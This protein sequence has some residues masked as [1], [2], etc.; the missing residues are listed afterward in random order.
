MDCR[1]DSQDP[2]VLPSA[3]PLLRVLGAFVAGR[4]LRSPRDVMRKQ[5]WRQ[6]VVQGLSGHRAD[7]LYPQLNWTWHQRKNACRLQS[8]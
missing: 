2:W 4:L 6:R 1:H 5:A 7:V 3:L 8:C